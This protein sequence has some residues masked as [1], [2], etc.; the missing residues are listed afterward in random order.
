MPRR[1]ICFHHKQAIKKTRNNNAIFYFFIPLIQA[2]NY[3]KKNDGCIGKDAPVNFLTE[4][5]KRI[6]NKEGKFRSGLY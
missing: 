2:V 5:E 4:R 1:S 3:F 6:L